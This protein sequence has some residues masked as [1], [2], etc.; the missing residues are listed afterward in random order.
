MKPDP[1][2][3]YRNM[4][5][6][7]RFEEAVARIW[8][9]G[10]ISAEMH[11]STG[12]EGIVA[13][14]VD[15][16]GDGDA[17]ALDHRGTAPL[18]MRGVDMG[19]LLKEFLGRE[20]GLC[21][22]MGGH[23]HL[24]APEILSASSGIV[25]AAGPAACGFAYA[26][27]HL[28]PEGVAVAFFGECA[29]NQGMLMES[30]NLASC[31]KLPVLFVCK[32]NGMG[33]TTPASKVT[34]G[35]LLERARGLGARAVAVDGV[36]VEAVWRV[37]GEAINR[38]RNGKGPTYLHATCV[39]PEGHFM[40]DPLLRIARKPTEEMRDKIGPLMSAAVSRGASL[41]T[42]AASLSLIASALGKAARSQ[43]GQ[44]NDPV[45]RLRKRLEIPEADLK[46][47]EDKIEA[48]IAQVLETAMNTEKEV[49]A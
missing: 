29:M 38:A 23:M 32:D 7:R 18:V 2:S 34:G 35:D 20:D 4:L 10:K 36:D 6:S 46:T 33:I 28:R 30:I 13:G 12:E 19:L 25:G 27:Q 5:R 39:R 47:L 45:A 31:W 22:G 16:L 48:E 9:E 3:L 43:F 42:R 40:G 24:F 11:M 37:A 49:H 44:K 15:H 14:V 17:M 8:L 21:R 41:G 1:L 26:A